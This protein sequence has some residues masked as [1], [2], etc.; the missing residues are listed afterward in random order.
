MQV[1]MQALF[2]KCLHNSKRLL[3]AVSMEATQTTPRICEICNMPCAKSGK[4]SDG[5]QRYRCGLCGRT[6]SDTKEHENVF[7]TKQAVDDSKALLV[8]QLLV[9]GN[10]IRST[11]R[12]TGI[13]RDTICGLLV[14]AGERAGA[15]MDSLV[16]NV[17]VS[18]VQVD[19]IWGFVGKKESRRVLGDKNYHKIGDAM[20]IHRH[21]AEH[22]TRPCIPPR[23]TKH[24]S[25]R[26]LCEETRR[27]HQRRYVPTDER[28]I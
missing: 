3:Y 11:E 24:G 25:N 22:E 1:K 17:P 20:D 7:G 13:H 16:R 9:E 5:L 8:L 4:R 26:Q 23:E 28:W 21:R 18:D 14:K 12:I 27:C 15:V 2:I 19:E 6:Y 10:S